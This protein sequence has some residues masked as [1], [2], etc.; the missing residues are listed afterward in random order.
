VMWTRPRPK[1]KNN[2]SLDRY[3]IGYGSRCADILFIAYRVAQ[4]FNLNFIPAN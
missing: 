3:G 4:I 1:L 2:Q